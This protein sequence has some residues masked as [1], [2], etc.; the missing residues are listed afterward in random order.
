MINLFV[1]VFLLIIGVLLVY[2]E[3]KSYKHKYA[4]ILSIF[5]LICFFGAGF[6]L[7]EFIKYLTGVKTLIF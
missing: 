3:I 1:S 4:I 5:R 7:S 6:F 2:Y